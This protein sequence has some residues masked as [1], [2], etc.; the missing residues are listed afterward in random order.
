DI[1]RK[2][3]DVRLSAEAG[4]ICDISWTKIPQRSSLLPSQRYAILSVG[5]TGGFG[6][7]R[8]A[9][10]TLLGGAA[11]PWRR[12]AA[13]VAHNRVPTASGFWFAPWLYPLRTRGTERISGERQWL[14]LVSD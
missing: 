8:R 1:S 6:L 13:R 10:I 2:A 9:F 4:V 14:F 7:K 12:S 11:A 3:R 5:S